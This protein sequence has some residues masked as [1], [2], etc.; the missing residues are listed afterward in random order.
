[1]F[2][3]H[4][5]GLNDRYDERCYNACS[6]SEFLY[7]TRVYVPIAT[8]PAN[9]IN[10]GLLIRRLV[11][12]LTMSKSVA[13]SDQPL[14]ANASIRRNVKGGALASDV[15]WQYIAATFAHMADVTGMLITPTID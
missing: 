7:I 11:L 10:T 2:S 4:D 12:G 5:Q 6:V 13:L 3:A 8:R 9:M 15:L 14:S 1:M